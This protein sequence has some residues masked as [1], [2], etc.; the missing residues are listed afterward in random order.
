[1]DLPLDFVSAV[2]IDSD[3]LLILELFEYHIVHIHFW[4][5]PL[6]IC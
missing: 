6:M 1:M 3:S 2:S 4:T 5:A